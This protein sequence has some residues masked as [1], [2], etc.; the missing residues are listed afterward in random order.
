M[1]A[2]CSFLPGYVQVTN[3][4]GRKRIAAHWG[5][6]DLPGQPG[7]TVVEMINA[8]G[9]GKIRGMYIM[10]ENPVVSDPDAHHVEE[11]LS[12]LDFLV[13]QDMFMT[14]TARMAHVVLPAAGWAEKEGSVVATDRRVQWMSRGIE[15]LDGAR[16]DW[17]ILCEVA[18]RLGFRFNYSGPEDILAEINRVVPMYAGITAQRIKQK[19]GGIPWPCPAPDHPGTPILH[20]ERFGTPDGLARL[21][22]VEYTPPAEETSDEYPLMLTTGRL[23][24][25]YNS[26]SMT[27][28]SG[29]LLKRSAELFVE[30][31]PSDAERI[32]VKNDEE[33]E[34]KTK[35][36]EAV[37]KAKVTDKLPPGVVF[38][39]FHF[40]GANA[41]TI[42]ALDRVAKIPE[43]KVAAC[44]IEK[45]SQN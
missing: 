16:A 32:H 25:H 41:L 10:G 30:I 36:G 37:A 40:A 15:P 11:A 19:T 26:G 39:P 7:L 29:A 12:R 38:M 5:M 4:Q 9:E 8:A 28:R 1:G 34:V 43:Y 3:E 44:R 14:E 2:L 20:V 21:I 22:P 33:V 42:S 35:R 31:N 6:E 13:V 27:R 45:R 24:I 17:R 23:V 18:D